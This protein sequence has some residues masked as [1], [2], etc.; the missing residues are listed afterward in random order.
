MLHSIVICVH[1]ERPLTLLSLRDAD[2]DEPVDSHERIQALPPELIKNNQSVL[3]RIVVGQPWGLR[4]REFTGG[5][6][7]P[8]RYSKLRDPIRLAV[9]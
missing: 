4:E 5:E 7:Q 8:F 2:S 3:R 1:S 9:C 6:F